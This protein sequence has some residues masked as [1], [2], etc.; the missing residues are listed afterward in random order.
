MTGN[1]SSFLQIIYKGIRHKK[2]LFL[3]GKGPVDEY[4][5]EEPLCFAASVLAPCQCI[6]FSFACCPYAYMYDR[7]SK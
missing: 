6:R 2:A 7:Q 3:P 1:V 4:I 5:N